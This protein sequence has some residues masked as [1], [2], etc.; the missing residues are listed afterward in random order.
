MIGALA[1]G[2]RL[3]DISSAACWSILIGDVDL[4]GV[5]QA[6][7]P[8]VF[9]DKLAGFSPCGFSPFRAMP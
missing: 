6:F 7:M 8:A 9:C 1:P 3:E 5:E 2:I 4:Y